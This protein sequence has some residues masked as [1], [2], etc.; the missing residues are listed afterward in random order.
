[1]GR[2]AALPYGLLVFYCL[3]G[4]LFIPT[5]AKAQEQTGEM[6]PEELVVV[7][8]E[9]EPFV[10]FE[11]TRI[12]GF[13]IELWEEIANRLGVAYE[14]EVV[15]LVGEQIDATA[16]GAA[17]VA[18][19]G[20]S[21]TAERE[22][23]IDYSHPY[24]ESNLKL[25]IPTGTRELRTVRQVFG[26]FFSPAVWRISVVFFGLIL[27]VAHII[28][29]VDRGRN[30]DFPSNY[31]VGIWESIW[32][33]AVTVT[34]VGYGDKTPKSRAGRV[35]GLFWMFSGLFLLANFTA[36][37]TTV[38]AVQHL[39]V[40]V[41]SLEDIATDGIATI[42]G[43]TASNYLQE[44]GFTVLETET[45]AEAVAYMNRGAA[46]GIFY[47]APTLEYY[48]HTVGGRHVTILPEIYERDM[49]GIALPEDSPLRTPIN[50]AL[51]ETI[52]D[53]TYDQIRRRWFGTGR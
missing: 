48:K 3:I 28:W 19:A 49:Y 31:L 2:K 39:S 27:V 45:L 25:M 18:I 29:L 51:L 5:A 1:M 50:I 38:L 8:K 40:Q 7:I 13:S 53:G 21:I 4:C 15:E 23:L 35:I 34:T 41:D 9:L 36:S 10:I 16:A 6:V 20:I 46:A 44:A 11:G 43:S 30:A 12:T 47:D 26:A 37:I 33:A 32:W 14:F 17:D 52:E 24:F 42:K 22:R